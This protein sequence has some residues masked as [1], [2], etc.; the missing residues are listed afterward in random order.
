MK[1]DGVGVISQR[2]HLFPFRTQKLSSAEATILVWRRTGKIAHRQH[3]TAKLNLRFSC[4]PL[5][6]S[7][8]SNRA[9]EKSVL[10]NA[11]IGR[12]RSLYRFDI[13]NH[14][15]SSL[16]QSVEHMTVNHGVVGSSPTG[17]ARKKG[18]AYAIPFFLAPSHCAYHQHPI[19]AVGGLW[20]SV[21]LRPRQAHLRA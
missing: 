6:I 14:L 21:A 15:Y 13:S 4:F 1:T 3:R 16:A 19:S 8:L 5:Y 10:L 20:A 9:V 2:V 7:L 11:C 18:I 17:G 12:P